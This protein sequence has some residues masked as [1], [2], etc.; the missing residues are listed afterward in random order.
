MHASRPW[1]LKLG[2]APADAGVDPA[3][4]VAQ[5]AVHSIEHFKGENYGS[6]CAD[7]A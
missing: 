6:S 2:I 3:T 4:D 5:D 1:V 7:V